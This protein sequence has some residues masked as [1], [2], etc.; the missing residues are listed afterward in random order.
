MKINNM[1]IHVLYFVNC[2]ITDKKLRLQLEGN[3]LLWQLAWN[4]KQ[5]AAQE[6]EASLLRFLR[7]GLESK[8]L[9]S[10]RISNIPKGMK[11]QK[12]LDKLKSYQKK[13]FH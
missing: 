3:F 5:R 11:L 9:D 6:I 13:C 2:M 12:I 4:I 10:L 1:N 8:I 7:P